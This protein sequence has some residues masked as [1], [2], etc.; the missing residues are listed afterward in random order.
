M[1]RRSPSYWEENLCSNHYMWSA[2]LDKETETRFE[3]KFSLPDYAFEVEAWQGVVTDKSTTG[4]TAWWRS[5]RG[6]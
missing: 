3:V 5:I 6:V 2:P 4:T 1:E